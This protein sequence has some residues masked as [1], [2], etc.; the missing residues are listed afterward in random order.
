MP[1]VTINVYILH[2]S[3]VIT[4]TSVLKAAFYSL[5]ILLLKELRKI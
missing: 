3:I 2:Y 1:R 5:N 4:D